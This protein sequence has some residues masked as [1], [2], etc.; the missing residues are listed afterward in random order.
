MRV[1]SDSDFV[2][3]AAKHDTNNQLDQYEAFI[4]ILN[5]LDIVHNM[6][7]NPNSSFSYLNLATVILIRNISFIFENWLSKQ[8]NTNTICN[9]INCIKCKNIHVPF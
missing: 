8:C 9:N 3:P 1:R 7:D 5:L 2:E 4:Q 6:L